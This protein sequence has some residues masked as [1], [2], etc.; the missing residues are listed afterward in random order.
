MI[1]LE[2]SEEDLRVFTGETSNANAKSSENF[3][4]PDQNWPNFGVFWELGGG[5][6]GTKSFDFYSKR[7]ILARI[8]VV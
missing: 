2:G 3:L 5:S 8:R 4:F 6:G 7:H 1:L